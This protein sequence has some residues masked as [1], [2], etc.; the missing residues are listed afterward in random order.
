MISFIAVAAIGCTPYVSMRPSYGYGYG[1]NYVQTYAAPTYAA[2]TYAAPSYNADY[3]AIVGNALR[4]EQYQKIEAE[5]LTK[6]TEALNRLESRI[7]TAT[8]APVATPA[9][10]PAPVAQPVEL[11]Q[12][13]A[14][15]TKAYPSPQTAYVPQQQAV[16]QM[17]SKSLPP[18]ATPQSLD[19]PSLPS[20]AAPQ[21][22]GD[23]YDH[24]I[25]AVSPPPIISGTP[26]Q[27]TGALD[28]QV[29]AM[30]TQDCRKCHGADVA[31]TK[32][33]GFTMF[34][35]DGAI[36][37]LDILDLKNIATKVA[38]GEM[39]KGNPYDA[40]RRDLVK[41]WDESRAQ[42]FLAAIR[43]IRSSSR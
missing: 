41:R 25:G 19:S 14:I 37:D 43:Q 29:L 15:P 32:G 13:V 4:Q 34:K 16:P 42:E 12:P 8:A 20:K 7:A 1:Y 26:D 39:P 18:A 3:F 9:P 11:P 31:T 33:G 24:G 23:S 17:P 28:Q 6:L 10:A 40:S 35:S 38:L 27:H 21:A 36:A 30:F 5:R 2:A 22:A